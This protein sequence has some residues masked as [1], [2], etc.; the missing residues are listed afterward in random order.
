MTAARAREAS[1]LHVGHGVDSVDALE[2]L[3]MPLSV[4]AA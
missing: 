4:G 2:P 1:G 3:P